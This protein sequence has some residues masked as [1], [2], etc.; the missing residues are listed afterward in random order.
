MSSRHQPQQGADS[1]DALMASGLHECASDCPIEPTHWQDRTCDYCSKT[2]WTG[3]LRKVHMAGATSHLC[4]DCF[5]RQQF[6]YERA[7]S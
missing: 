3:P 2:Q 4:N 6:A 1:H 5:L 7:V